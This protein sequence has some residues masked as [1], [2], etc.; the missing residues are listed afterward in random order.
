MRFITEPTPLKNLFE[1]RQTGYVELLKFA[2]DIEN[3]WIAIDGEMHADCE[4]LLLEKGSKQE[5]IWGGNIYPGNT[6]PDLLEFSSFIN[7]RPSRD[8]PGMDVMNPEIREEI[9]KIV[10]QLLVF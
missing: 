8:N 6:E 1:N 2:V 4:T 5:N 10:Q 7:I 9:R 3:M